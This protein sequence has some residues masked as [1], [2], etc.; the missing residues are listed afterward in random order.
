MDWLEAEDI[1]TEKNVPFQFHNHRY[2][3]DILKD[4]AAIQVWMKAAQVGMTTGAL[5]KVAHWAK[6]KKYNIIY[7]LPTVEDAEFIVQSKWEPILAQNPAMATWMGDKSTKTVKELDNAFIFFRGTWAQKDAISVTSDLNVHDEL[8]RSNL[9]T[10]GTYESRVLQSDYQGQWFFSNPSI[11]NQGVD[12]YWQESD[13]KHWYVTCEHCGHEQYLDWPDSICK[14]RGIYVCTKCDKE[15]SDDV[16]REGKWVA[17]FPGKYISGYWINRMMAPST[18]AQQIIH[19][20]NTKDRAYFYNFVIG[21]PYIGSDTSV[22]RSILLQNGIDRPVEGNYCMGVDQGLNEKHVVIGTPETGVTDLYIVKEWEEVAQL[23]RKFNC[24]NIVIDALPDT[25]SVKDLQAEFPFQIMMCYYRRDPAKPESVEYKELEG[26]V[27]AARS[28]NIDELIQDLL[29]TRF[30]YSQELIRQG[31]WEVYCK[32]WES[33]YLVFEED[34]TTG[35]RRRVWKNSRADH[36]VHATLYWRL[37]AKRAMDM[38][39]SPLYVPEDDPSTVM[40]PEDDFDWLMR[41]DKFEDWM[42]G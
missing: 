33:L 29:D 37:A 7:T 2:M 5:I 13:Q 32:H 14:E 35:A 30:P 19:S 41:T 36:F 27:F 18:S 16:R 1:V 39:E 22:S 10:V 20:F 26:A 23:I 38:N 40:N 9:E 24:G 17:H 3:I 21:K 34:K 8:D 11:P 31:L 4:E 12:A 25:K 28:R 6:Y 42:D 15:L